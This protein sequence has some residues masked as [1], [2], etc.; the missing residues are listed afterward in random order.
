[1]IEN[2][3]DIVEVTAEYGGYARWTKKAAIS[4]KAVA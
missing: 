1:M 2:E 4:Q 3:N